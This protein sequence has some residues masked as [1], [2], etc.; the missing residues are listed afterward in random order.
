MFVVVASIPLL[1][2]LLLGA[3]AA[4]LLTIGRS[5]R[6]RE[7]RSVHLEQ[8]KRVDDMLDQGRSL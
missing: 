8:R 4:Y 6:Y 2:M 3:R 7:L 5:H 1:A